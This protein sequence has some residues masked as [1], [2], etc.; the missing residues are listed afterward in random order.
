MV[1]LP[2]WRP[3]IFVAANPIETDGAKLLGAP[4]GTKPFRTNFVARRLSKATASVAALECLPPSAYLTVLRFCINESVNYLAQVTD[5]PLVQDSLARMDT[6]IDHVLLR[7]A[8]S[9]LE[10]PLTHLTALTLRS[11]PAEL[12]GLGIRRYRGLAGEITCLRGRMVFY[13]FV[14]HYAPGELLADATEELW[15]PITLD[16]PRTQSGRR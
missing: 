13:E 1:W 7:A 16:A 2:I 4:I 8:G 5:F 12:G 6:I 11:L 15:M 9:P 10:P 3:G 14:E